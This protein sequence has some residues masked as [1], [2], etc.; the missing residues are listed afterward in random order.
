MSYD[1]DVPQRA[2]Q[3]VKSQFSC[4]G[5]ESDMVYFSCGTE[6][7]YYCN[8]YFAEIYSLPAKLEVEPFPCT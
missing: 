6:E 4:R 5:V 3:S 2:Y 8:E 1:A 7:Y